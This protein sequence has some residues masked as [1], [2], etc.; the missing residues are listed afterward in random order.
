MHWY[1]YGAL[2]RDTSASERELNIAITMFTPCFINDIDPMPEPLSSVLADQA[3]PIAVDLFDSAF[4]APDEAYLRVA[5]RLPAAD[6]GYPSGYHLSRP[7]MLSDARHRVVNSSSEP[8]ITA[9]QARTRIDDLPLRR[10]LALFW[11]AAISARATPG[12]RPLM[13]MWCVRTSRAHASL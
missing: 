7:A 12:S 2:R 8:E 5:I 13:P 9:G 6:S 10:E 11:S 1:G 3:A 4:A